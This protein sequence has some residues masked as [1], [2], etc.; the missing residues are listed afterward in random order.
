M[1]IEHFQGAAGDA[2]GGL[3]DEGRRKLALAPD[4]RLAGPLVRVACRDAHSPTFGEQELLDHVLAVMRA[5]GYRF[6]R[7]QVVS[8][9]VSLKTNPFVVLVGAAGCGKTEL[10]SLF[11]EALVGRDSMQYALIPGAGPRDAAGGQAGRYRSL[12]DQFSGWRFVHLLQEAAEPCNAGKAYLICFDALHPDELEYFFATLLEVGPD[13]QRWLNLPGYAGE[14]RP[15][16]PP[17]VYITATVNSDQYADALSRRVLRHAGVIECR[18][19]LLRAEPS[20]GDGRAERAAGLGSPPPGYQRLWL[21]AA[22][23]DVAAA[24][25]R[26]VAIL[27]PDFVTR[28]HCSAELQR[29]TWRVGYALKRQNLREL[30]VYI[31]N[32]FDER[33]GGLFDPH[34]RE[35]NAR[36][37]YDAQ[38][39]QRVIWRLRAQED[40]DLRRDLSDYL[41]RLARSEYQQAVA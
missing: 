9:Y 33:G 41:D 29:L 17:N 10:A 5:A 22:L 3:A 1:I 13:G 35:R 11:A 31:A 14:R 28:L 26:A 39:L 20:P 8:Y 27:G 19:L 32:S 38:V 18:A 36:I 30:A 4:R 7:S 37:A 2:A 23:N 16:V 40:A 34:D 25:A 15:G 24:Q 21:R 12:Q 6:S